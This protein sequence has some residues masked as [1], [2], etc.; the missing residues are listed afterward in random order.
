MS[1]EWYPDVPGVAIVELEIARSGRITSS[2]LARSSDDEA[3]DKA[4]LA[5]VAPGTKMPPLPAETKLKSLL[6]QIPMYFKP[7]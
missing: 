4:A 1:T 2:S 7:K 5:V 6:M 3:I